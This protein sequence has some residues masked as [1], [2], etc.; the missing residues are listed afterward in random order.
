MQARWRVLSGFDVG[1]EDGE[2]NLF[3]EF[4]AAVVVLAA[5]FPGHALGVSAA[6]QVVV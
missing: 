5:V 1:F 3:I 4:T 2:G 6:G